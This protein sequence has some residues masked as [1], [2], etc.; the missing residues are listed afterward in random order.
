MLLWSMKLINLILFQYLEDAFMGTP[1]P[2]WG[3]SKSD[4]S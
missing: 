3:K 1:I 4:S 2:F